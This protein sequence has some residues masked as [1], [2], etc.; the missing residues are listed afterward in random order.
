MD[1]AHI[2]SQF[3]HEI[4]LSHRPKTNDMITAAAG[5]QFAVRTECHRVRTAGMSRKR[6]DYLSVIGIDHFKWSFNVNPTFTGIELRYG[7]R[8]RL[9]AEAAKWIAD[10]YSQAAARLLGILTRGGHLCHSLVHRRSVN[11]RDHFSFR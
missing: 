11:F 6:A 7:R 5:Q 10:K 3:V 2:A 4:A 1:R 8:L 9:L